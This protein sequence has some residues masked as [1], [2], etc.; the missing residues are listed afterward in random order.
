MIITIESKALQSAI[1]IAG[2]VIPQKSPWPIFT[3]LKIVASDGKLTLIGSDGDSTFEA[4]IPADC[5]GEEAFCVPFEPLV[6]FLR[7]AKSETVK[8]TLDDGRA[9]IG[10]GRSRIS[11]SA[12]PTDDYPNFTP[13]TGDMVTVDADTFC[14]ALRFTLSAVDDDDMKKHLSGANIAE[15]DGATVFWGTNGKA[16]HRAKIADLPNIGDGATLPIGGARVILSIGADQDRAQILICDRG[17]VIE[18]PNLRAWGKVTEDRFPDM[19]RVVAQ[20]GQWDEIALASGND[21]SGAVQ[22]A[23]CGAETDSAK[24]RNLII[25]CVNGGDMI[26]QGQ[27]AIGGVSQP[28]RAE[29]RDAAR[30]DFVCVISERFVSAAIAGMGAPDLVVEGCKEDGGDIGRAIRIIPAQES[31]ILEMSALIMAQRTSQ[32]EVANV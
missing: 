20:F 8:I 5:S 23:T 22:V 21:I 29:V 11:L 3:N 18:V 15:V 32:A 25:K 4:D 17:W 10:A 12:L 24:S 13:P 9:K 26:I 31:D 19:S 16:A 30:D 27:K 2:K 7:A 1:A 14:K 28:G 6:K